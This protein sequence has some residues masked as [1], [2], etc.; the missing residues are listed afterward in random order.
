MT[1]AD[2]TTGLPH[3]L[4][5]LLL[6]LTVT[7]CSPRAFAERIVVRGDAPAETGNAYGVSPQ[8]V[9]DVYR[10]GASR[11]APPVI[12]FLYGGRWS[13]GT[14][15]DYRALANA[16]TGR[17]WIVIVPDYRLYPDV[18]FPAWVEDGAR[19][20]R[21]AFDN[22]ARLGG[23]TARVSVVGHSAGGHTAALLALDE[24]YLRAAGVSPG[25]VR[26]YVSIAGPV[27]TTWTDPDIQ[28]L[29]GPKEGWAATY[30]ATFI[31]GTERPVLFLH[32][33]DDK[34]V[35]YLHS[36][37]LAERIRAVG[38]CAAARIYDGIGHVPIILAAMFPSL[39]SAPVLN[40][41]I[42]FIQDP[43]AQC[44]RGGGSI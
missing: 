39:A 30:P 38:G 19:A 14:R 3:C 33:S 16:F 29:M 1:R 23:D 4:S 11:T 10:P 24:R 7:A 37:R 6:A 42:R 22:A 31:D 35:S 21:W 15:H 25:S 13:S 41:V 28:A 26:A 17:G 36:I 44:A 5:S 20:I 2:W 32:G 43:A 9:L 27:E 40:D 18:K 12:V 34:T 8:Q